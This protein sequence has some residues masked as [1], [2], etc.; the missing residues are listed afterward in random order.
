MEQTALKTRLGTIIATILLG[1]AVFLLPVL[2]LAAQGQN[3][4]TFQPLSQ[5]DYLTLGLNLSQADADILRSTGELVRYHNSKPTLALLPDTRIL[6]AI[7]AGFADT[8]ADLAIETLLVYPLPASY[9]SNPDQKVPSAL[10]LAIY[11][12]LHR[13]K[14][15]EGIKYYSASRKEM[16]TF[17]IK[18][19]LVESPSNRKSIPDPVYAN[20]EALHTVYAQQ[21]DSTFGNNLYQVEIRTLDPDTMALRMQNAEQIWYGLI[22]VL[23]AKGLDMHVLIMK[24]GNYLLFYG[25]SGFSVPKMLGI[26]DKAR[27][28]FYNRLIALFSWF[29]GEMGK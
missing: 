11:N 3:G 19:S 8:K 9:T 13:F 4:K 5:Q 17:F 22:P 10:T 23:S 20:T 15:M 25:T 28:S 14:S 18:S 24:R 7:N 29:T 26:D 1:L 6:G 2:P 27:S 21:E 16:R 12:T